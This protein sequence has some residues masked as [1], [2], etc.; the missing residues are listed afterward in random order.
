M[1]HFYSHL[2][3]IDTVTVKLDE[4]DLTQEQKMHLAALVDSTIHH[5][6]LEMILSKLSEADKK[7]FLAK[8]KDDPKDQKIMEFLNSKVEGIEDEIKKTIKEL[9]D[10]LHEDIKEAKNQ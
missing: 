4:L 5:T 9:K 3:E 7:A 1:A 2:V 10:E 8:L 6:V